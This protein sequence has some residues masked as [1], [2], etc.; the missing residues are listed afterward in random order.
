MKKLISI[1]A[2]VVLAASGCAPTTATQSGDATGVNRPSSSSSSSSSSS[3]AEPAAD[4]ETEEPEPSDEDT[5][6]KFGESATFDDGLV[7]NVSKPKVFKPSEYAAFDKAKA[8][9]KFTITVVNRTGKTFDPTGVY[10]TVQSANEEASTVFDSD[11]NIGGGPS[12]K[13]LKNREAKWVIGF[14]VQNPKDLVMEISPGA[15]EYDDIL[16]TN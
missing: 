4:L 7:I 16:Y 14:G 5:E 15:F 8:Y 2:L 9:V 3:P 10:A 6:L 11:K 12:T 13:L 1:T